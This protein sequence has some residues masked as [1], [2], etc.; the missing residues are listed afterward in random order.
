MQQPMRNLA[1]AQG[2]EQ[3]DMVER[4]WFALC[5]HDASPDI[6]AHW[7][8]WKRLLAEPFMAPSLPASEV[9]ASVRLMD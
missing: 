6:A 5:T 3:E 9:V 7:E 4:A 2:L 8:N 1:I